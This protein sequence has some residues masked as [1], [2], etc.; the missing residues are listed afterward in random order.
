HATTRLVLCR[1]G[2]ATTTSCAD[3]SRIIEDL[4]RANRA[5]Y[6]TRRATAKQLIL[7]RLLQRDQCPACPQ[8]VRWPSP[9]AGLRGAL[10]A[11]TCADAPPLRPRKEGDGPLDRPLR[12]RNR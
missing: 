4:E 8:R 12:F 3:V 2:G 5:L 9:D 11:L 7:G 6:C 10:R 1:G